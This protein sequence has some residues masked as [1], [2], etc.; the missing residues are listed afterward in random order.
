MFSFRLRSSSGC[1]LLSE[2]EQRRRLGGAP[3]VVMSRSAR[4]V[5]RS[6]WTIEKRTRV[7]SS[8]VGQVWPGSDS[9]EHTIE[10]SAASEMHS[11]GAIDPSSASTTSA[12]VISRGRAGEHVAAARAAPRVDQAGLAQARHEVLEV[13]Q[14]QAVVGGDLRE[15]D[16]LLAGPPSE[17]DH[18]AHAVLGLC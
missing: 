1:G 17:L 4:V 18:H 8:F 16:R 10:P 14:R 9:R 3:A 2:V 13:G 6:V 15:R 5:S 7:H 12:I 11:I